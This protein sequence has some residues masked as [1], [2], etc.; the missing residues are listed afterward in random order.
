MLL[1]EEKR[2]AV[3]AQ[4]R[5]RLRESLRSSP[6][7]APP[8][9]RVALQCPATTHGAPHA[10]PSVGTPRP[11]S[12]ERSRSTSQSRPI[13]AGARLLLAGAAARRRPAGE[14]QA[15]TMADDQQQRTNGGGVPLVGSTVYDT[16]LYGSGD[17]AGFRRELVDE[18]DDDQDLG[19]GG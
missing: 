5:Q 15:A 6:H 11:I 12:A 9:V 18:E 19:G 17:K 3:P 16:D 10:T 7:K 14:R 8:P 2:E 4:S 1:E 13:S